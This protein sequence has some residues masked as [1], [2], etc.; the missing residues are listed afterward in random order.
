MPTPFDEA[1]SPFEREPYD[2]EPR[3]E[4]IRAI[5]ALTLTAFF[6]GLITFYL[7]ASLYI[8]NT[9]VHEWDQVKEAFQVVFPATSGVLGTAIAFFFGK[10]KS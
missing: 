3:R 10:G 8:H 7:Y 5:V 2:P 4:W 6:I 1:N 9:T